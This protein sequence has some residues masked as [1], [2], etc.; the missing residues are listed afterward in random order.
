METH[1]GLEWHE[2]KKIQQ[3]VF[4]FYVFGVNTQP[5]SEEDLPS[6]E[7]IQMRGR[8]SYKRGVCE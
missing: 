4:F 2:D 6:Y 7:Q 5:P 3:N 1:K 8:L